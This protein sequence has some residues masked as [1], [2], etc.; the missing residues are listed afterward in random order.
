LR[1]DHEEMVRPTPISCRR[2]FSSPPVRE[3]GV[4]P[5]SWHSELRNTSRSARQDQ[6]VTGLGGMSGR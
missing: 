3:A 4:G 5:M 6:D 2:T 1:D